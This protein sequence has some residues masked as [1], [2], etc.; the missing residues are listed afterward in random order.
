MRERTAAVWSYSPMAPLAAPVRE[1]DAPAGDGLVL[2]RPVRSRGCGR[3]LT[4]RTSLLGQHAQGHVPLLRRN[5]IRLDEV[6]ETL[7]YEYELESLQVELVKLQRWVQEKGRRIAILFEGRDAA[8]KG[9][10]IRRFTEHLNP[11]AMRVVALPSRP[12]RS[13]ASGT[14]SATCA[15]SRTAARSSSSTAAG[16]TAP[17]WSRSTDSAPRIS[18]SASCSRCRS[19][20]TCSYEDGMTIVK[21]WF[22]I[23]KEVQLRRFESRETTRSSSGSSAR[24]TKG[25]GAVGHLHAATRNRCSAGRTRASARGS[26]CGR[27]TRSRRGSR[28]SATC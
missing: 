11:R 16:T 19:S 25:A 7:D 21:F 17:W 26:S 1:A 5:R 14:S 22:S 12:T 6:F 23:S 4:T 2:A 28:A 18:T 20:S 10:T 8:G 13:A 27:T 24:S 3:D 15:S 9:G